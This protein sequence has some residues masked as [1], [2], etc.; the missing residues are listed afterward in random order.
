MNSRQ[1]H[2]FGKD[3]VLPRAN[4]PIVS[5]GTVLGKFPQNLSFQVAWTPVILFSAILV[6]PLT[7][8]QSRGVA[9]S[10]VQICF[11][12]FNHKKCETFVGKCPGKMMLEMMF[13]TILCSEH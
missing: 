4:G 3:E 9:S 2:E 5:S 6:F 10:Q 11:S 1:S 13:E 8:V 12:S 7:R